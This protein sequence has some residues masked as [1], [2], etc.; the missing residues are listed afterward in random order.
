MH[1]FS[2]PLPAHELLPHEPD[3]K[4][5]ELQ[6]EP[7]VPEPEEQVRAENDG[8]R[9]EAEHIATAARPGQ[10]HVEGVGEHQLRHE[11]PNEVVDRPP[12][13]APVREHGYLNER[14]QVMLGT[15]HGMEGPALRHTLEPQEERRLP[16][17]QYDGRTPKGASENRV[18]RYAGHERQHGETQRQRQGYQEHA[19]R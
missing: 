10:K 13:P 18:A 11:K 8:K 7:V 3:R 6:V 1:P 17:E 9:P 15:Q 12:V 5:E 4:H 19:T 14:L 2:F 16:D